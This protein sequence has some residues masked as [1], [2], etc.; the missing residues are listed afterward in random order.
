MQDT[1]TSGSMQNG[2]GRRRRLWQVL[3]GLS[4][5][6]IAFAIF[7]WQQ[8][9]DGRHV[10]P[11][12][13]IAEAAQRTQSEPGGRAEM[14]TV[15]SS[16][17]RPAPLT[18][19]GQV[20]FD[21]DGRS[22]MV[23]TVPQV[24]GDDPVKMEVV[25]DG[26]VMYMRSSQFGSLPDGS[27]WMALDLA[28]FGEEPDAPLPA[29]GDAKGEL[30]LLEAVTGKVQ[31]LG[32]EDVRGV[33]TTRYRGTVDASENAERL[34]EEGAEDLASGVEEGDPLQVEAW[35]DAKG[36]VRR[37]RFVHSQPEEKGK[38]STTMDMTMD[39]FDFGI[40]PEIDVPDQ[41]EVFDATAQTREKLGFDD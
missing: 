22:R 7:V 38:G 25:T 18:I 29:S 3:I 33:P 13:A 1:K 11:L 8:G 16:P 14:R 20:V 10:G 37:M 30:A 28:S 9:D 39:F 36:L 35:I 34:R 12:N 6:V 21:A 2:P 41:D 17:T 5:L 23:M 26:A 19:T 24:N 32:K 27:G 40:T 15:V 4:I 31:K